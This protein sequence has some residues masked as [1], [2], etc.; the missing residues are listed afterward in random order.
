MVFLIDYFR[1]LLKFLL[2]SMLHINS[3]ITV[4]EIFGKII[5]G[6]RIVSLRNIEFIQYLFQQING[7]IFVL[8]AHYRPH[9]TV[10]RVYRHLYTV[11][12]VLVVHQFQS[13]KIKN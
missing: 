4:L 11:F 8:S 3:F 13:Y 1:L 9:C 12:C 7:F 5:V 6:K 2:L 10:E